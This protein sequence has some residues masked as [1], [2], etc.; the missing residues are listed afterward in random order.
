ML[1]QILKDDISSNS[2]S[3]SSNLKQCGDFFRFDSQFY[4]LML[5]YRC[6]LS[7]IQIDLVTLECWNC[8]IIL[9]IVLL[10]F[11]FLYFSFLY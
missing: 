10:S 3:F 5:N 1:T 2:V 7:G 6:V 11:Q 4:F 8:V 9:F